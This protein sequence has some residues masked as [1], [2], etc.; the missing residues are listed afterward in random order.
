MSKFAVITDNCTKDLLCVD[1]CAVE[2]IHPTAD[3]PKLAEVPQLYIDPAACVNCGSCIATCEREAIFEDDE[4][5]D[6]NK[7]FIE[8]N[9]AYYKS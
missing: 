3:E 1:V 8:I 5:S 6:E 9:A 4:L 2:A 7:K